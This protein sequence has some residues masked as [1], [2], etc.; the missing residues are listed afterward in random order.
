MKKP[1]IHIEVEPFGPEVADD[2]FVDLVLD[3]P[4]GAHV[5]IPF[6]QKEL[7]ELLSKLEQGRL[8]LELLI[9]RGGA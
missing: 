9:K 5:R 4:S 1:Q 8:D 7:K 6:E 2:P 3:L